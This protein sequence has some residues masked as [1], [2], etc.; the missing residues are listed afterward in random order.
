M[1]TELVVL[2]R[3]IKVA[4]RNR[5]RWLVA[6]MY[7]AFAAFIV[8]WAGF[9]RY[10][11]LTA[12]CMVLVVAL[13][14][15]FSSIAGSRYDPADER[16]IRRREHAHYVAYWQLSKFL[17]LALFSGYFRGPNPITP[18]MAPA[19]RAVLVQ[20]PFVFLMATGVL[21]ITL[22]QAILL[23]TEPDMETD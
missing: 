22:P 1:K 6:L 5:R 20:L 2:G 16:D 15:V 7:V 17:I 19:L 9:S 21:Y 14:V 4:S 18:L 11:V 13:A 8:V 10:G 12:G 23:W 3:H